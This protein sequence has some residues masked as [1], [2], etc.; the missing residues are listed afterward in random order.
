MEKSTYTVKEVAALFGT[1]EQK[2]R[3][4]LKHRH[5][6]HYQNGRGKIRIPKTELEKIEYFLKYKPNL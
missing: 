1:Y 4:I 3:E 2:I 6:L 5:I